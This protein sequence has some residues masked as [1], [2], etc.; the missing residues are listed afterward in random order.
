M[1]S[2]RKCSTPACRH[3]GRQAVAR[4][5]KGSSMTTTH[6]PN[7]ILF[8]N[9]A[10]EPTGTADAHLAV[11]WSNALAWRLAAMRHDPAGAAAL[12]V[13]AKA[14]TGDAWQFICQV[15]LQHMAIGVVA[16]VVPDIDTDFVR[17]V[18]PELEKAANVSEHELAEYQASLNGPDALD[19]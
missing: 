2:V 18:A 6:L 14:D 10:E 4:Y 15:A 13:Q 12:I 9:S 5:Q 11:L 8:T 1:R 19:S 17:T 7:T 16:N 3:L